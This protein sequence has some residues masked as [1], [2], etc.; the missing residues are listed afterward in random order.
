MCRGR[1]ET[2]TRDRP[3][4]NYGLD[5]MTALLFDHGQC[6]TGVDTGR[7]TAFIYPLDVPN[8]KK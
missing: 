8:L 3:Q 1:Q 6:M 2:Q 5:L 4:T 7:S